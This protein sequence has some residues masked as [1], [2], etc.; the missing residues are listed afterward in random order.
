[1]LE[2]KMRGLLVLA[3]VLALPLGTAIAAPQVKVPGCDVIDAWAAKVIPND[4]YNLAPRIALPKAFQDSDL[5]PVYGI[6]VRS[7]SQEDVQAASQSLVN[8]YQDAGKRRDQ[9]A[10]GAL[11]NANRALIGLVPRTNAALQQAKTAADTLKRQIDAL[12]DSNELAR[13]IDSLVKGNPAAPD[14]NA[15][16]G[17]PR[18]VGDPIWRLAQTVLTL[19]DTDREPLYKALGERSSTIQANLGSDAEKTIAG[20]AQDAGGVIAVMEVRQRVAALSDADAKAKLTKQADDQAQKIR[21]ALRQAKPPVWVPPTCIDLYRWSSAQGANGGV[22]VGGRGVMAAFLDDRAVPVFGISVSDWSDQDI[23]RF[24]SLRTLC[25]AASQP[26]AAA[27]GGPEAAALVQTASRG[28]WIEGADQQIADARTTLATYHKAKDELAA[29]L[30]KA[31]ALPDTTASMLPLAQLAVDPAQNAVTQEDRVAFANAINQKRASIGAH[32]T[33]AA[34][35]GLADIKIDTLADLQKLFAY[36]GQTAAAIPDPRGQQAFAA[37]ANR[38]L[39]DAAARL[40]PEFQSTLAALPANF[41]GAAQ[42]NAELAK[43]TGIPDAS[44]SRL[45]AFKPYHDAAQARSAAIVK[46]VHDQAC[47]DL[48]SSLGAGSDATQQVWD[49]DQGMSLGDFICG[50]ASHGAAVSSYSGAG[51]FSGTTTLKLAPLKESI[52][53]VS[54]HKVEVKAGTSMLVGFKVVDANGQQ[55]SIIGAIGGPQGDTKGDA[56][57]TTEGWEFYAGQAKGFNPNE[58]EVCKT[59]ITQSPDKLGPGETLFWLDC[60]TLPSVI[61]ARNFGEK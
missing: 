2:E 35:K 16:R 18:E 55:V 22:A 12:P 47:S 46:T 42:A 21:D 11:A 6:S 15:F 31:Q 32:A 13:G 58:D 14:I 29:A 59:L 23:A 41:D 52:E 49:G 34:V 26:S 48:L 36:V 5:V 1:M 33:D 56:A 30:A 7:W 37:A 40:L 39:Q 17:L 38:T 28:R 54:M 43:L 3:A 61:R 27:S 57:L 53:T 9:A 10:A 19:A 25:Q 50:L 4:N 24:K 51:M 8:C 44:T 45:P 20:A 60:Q